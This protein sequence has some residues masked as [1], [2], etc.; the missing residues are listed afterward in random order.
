MCGMMS[1][2]LSDSGLPLWMFAA[3]VLCCPVAT[4]APRS[5]RSFSRAA[6]LPRIACPAPG[7]ISGFEGIV[8]PADGYV[9]PGSD[10]A[11]CARLV[12]VGRPSPW[13]RELLHVAPIPAPS[14][15]RPPP[16]VA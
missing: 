16:R 15:A 9:Q 14:R 4:S 12:V 6:H 5:G 7:V 1:K 13:T 3:S 2:T 11:R 10:S 8:L